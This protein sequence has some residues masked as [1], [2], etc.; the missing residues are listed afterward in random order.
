MH[1]GILFSIPVNESGKMLILSRFIVQS[2]GN[3]PRQTRSSAAN[4]K[5]VWAQ[6]Q[7]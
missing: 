4:R 5:I 1:G 3:H 7:R 6:V 2:D